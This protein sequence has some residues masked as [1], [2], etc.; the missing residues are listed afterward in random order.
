MHAHGSDRVRV[1]GDKVILWSPIPKGWHPRVPRTNVHSEHPGTAVLW[2]EEY[3]EVVEAS[4]AQGGGV[5]YVLAAW[6]DE[7]VFRVFETYDDESEARRIADFNAASKQRRHSGA[8]WLLGVIFGHLPAPIQNRIANEYGRAAHRM[9]LISIV[10]SQILLGV[11]VWFYVDA[12]MKQTSSIIPQW[13]W[14]LAMVMLA[15][16][17]VRFLV[18][19][20]QSRP[21]GSLPGTLI[22]FVLWKLAPKRFPSPIEERGR[23]VFMIEP[24]EA[25]AL[26]DAIEMRAPLFTLLSP[27]EQ[28]LLA[29]RFGFEYRKHATAPAV[30]I[31]IGALLGVVSSYVKVADSGG[32]SALL[33]LFVAGALTIEQ[34]LRLVS[35]KRGP[36]GSM[37]APLVRP[38]VRRYLA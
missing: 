14:I 31:L 19:M 9:T 30:I 34:I 12:R 18:V 15:D 22:Y 6:R 1:A 35:F 11:C 10:P 3:Y 21:Q 23:A 27:P 2:G 17:A 5:R 4:A 13:M 24:D 29:E 33:S 37:L 7:H 20:L 36:A 26:Q 8:V 16:S 32:L 28:H 25:I 38:F